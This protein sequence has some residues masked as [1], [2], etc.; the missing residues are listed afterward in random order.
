M[1]NWASRR[2]SWCPRGFGQSRNCVGCA[3]RKFMRA[4]GTIQDLEVLRIAVGKA[5]AQP[6][7]IFDDGD[8]DLC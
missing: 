1:A 8:I 6:R 2:P 5:K 7:A 3:A 4:A